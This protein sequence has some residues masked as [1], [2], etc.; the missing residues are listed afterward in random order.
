MILL[1]TL[2]AA[3]LIT[4][5]LIPLFNSLALRWQLVDLPSPR[6]IHERPIPRVGGVAMALGALVPIMYWNYA[7][8]FVQAFLI[9][10]CLLVLFGAYDD[11][12]EL[13]PK[14]KF[15]GH[16]FLHQA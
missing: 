15:A 8:S 14:I 16:Q 1:S 3:V 13:S 6:K 4:I 9:G 2:L 11:V 10:G 12:R 5:I 7:D